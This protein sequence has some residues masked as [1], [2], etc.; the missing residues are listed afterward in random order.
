MACVQNSLMKNNKIAEESQALQLFPF[1]SKRSDLF[2]VG[3]S[4]HVFPSRDK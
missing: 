3:R 1:S 4:L 2:S